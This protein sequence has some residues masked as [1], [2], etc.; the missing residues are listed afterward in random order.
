MQFYVLTTRR[1]Q[2]NHTT[3]TIWFETSN[4]SEKFI[5]AAVL[6]HWS[7]AI[8]LFL[9]WSASGHFSMKASK[10]FWIFF[11]IKNLR[12]FYLFEL[13]EFHTLSPATPYGNTNFI[14]FFLIFTLCPL[15]FVQ[16]T[17]RSLESMAKWRWRR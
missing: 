9:M 14:N 15:K 11:I 4:K 12:F 1:V 3:A 2:K 10:S 8:K 13:S 16:S 6:F 5:A 7:V 17:T